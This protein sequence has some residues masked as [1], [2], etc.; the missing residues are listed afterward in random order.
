MS[1][2]ADRLPD[3]TGR[4]LRK[5]NARFNAKLI[6]ALIV[7]DMTYDELAEETGLHYTTVREYVNA[8]LD[9]RVVRISAWDRDAQG[10]A[11]IRLFS[12]NPKG[13]PDAPRVASSSVARTRAY[14]K[15]KRA[16]TL[17]GLVGATACPT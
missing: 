7:G 4:T 1:S 14:R 2:P 13:L 3:I 8:M 15:R 5:Y 12:F 6:E 9:L 11:N 16:A 17:L 10:R